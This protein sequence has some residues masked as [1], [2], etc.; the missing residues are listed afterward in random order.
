MNPFSEYPQYDALGLAQL[1]QS[2]EVTAGEL[3]KAAQV[4]L[5]EF[6]PL[7]NAVVTPMDELAES[8]VK[9]LGNRGPFTGV[10]FLV[11]DLMLRFAGVTMSNGSVAMKDY[12]PA[13]D[14]EMAARLNAAGLITF[15]KTNN[16]EL[17]ASGLA[18]NAV[19]C[20]TCN[21]W[22]LSLNSGGSSGGSAAAVATRIVPMAYASDGGGSIRLPASYCGIFGFKPSRGLNRFEDLSKAW[23]GAVVSH[24]CTISVRDSAAY[25]DWVSGNT[26]QAYSATKPPPQSYL[27]A[28]TQPAKRLK[29]ALIKQAPVETLIHRDCLSAAAKAAKHCEALGHVVEEAVWNFDGRELMRAFLTVIFY[30]TTRDV[31]NMA[32]LLELTE[33]ELAIELN[34]R[35]LAAIGKGVSDEQLQQA[36]VVWQRIAA[37]LADF[38]RRYDIILTPT[39]AKPPLASDALD[40]NVVERW[41]MLG[42]LATGLADKLFS[43]RLLDAIISKAVQ[44]TPFTPLANITGQPAMSVPLYWSGDGLPHGAQFMAAA[45]HDRLLLQLAA[46]LEQI[47]PWKHRIPPLCHP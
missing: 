43:D 47:E 28:A 13:A 39:V 22:D 16:S 23:G 1:V 42:L 19:F 14:S 37:R 34:T 25:L 45:G 27:S 6:N 2:G 8:L 35:L 9:N 41:L 3:L 32:Q 4:R 17:G 30:Y 33:P 29:I 15:G 26:D 38:H 24:V 5:A 40:P 44:Q 10:P 20:S 31:A 7:L 18:N 36:L 12:R 21:P 46:Q 11:K